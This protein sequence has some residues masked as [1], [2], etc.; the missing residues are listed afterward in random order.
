L[1]ALG[2]ASLVELGERPVAEVF[3]NS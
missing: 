3:I 2:A 1:R